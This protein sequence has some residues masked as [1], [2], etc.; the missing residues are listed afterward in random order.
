MKIAVLLTCFNRKIK[1]LSCLQSLY[2]ALEVYNN[3]YE[4]KIDLS[5]YLT[6]DGCTD[7]TGNAVRENFIDKNITILQGTGNLFWA[8]GM[9]LAWNTALR[10]NKGWDFYLLLNDDVV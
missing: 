10:Y 9:C 1:T 7:G 4:N 2:H 3:K 6:D 5:I 8:G